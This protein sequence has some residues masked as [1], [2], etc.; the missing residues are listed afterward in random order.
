M[1]RAGL[2]ELDVAP[3][4]V[5]ALADLILDAIDGL[6]LDRLVS[7]DPARS[8]AAAAAFAELLEQVD[9]RES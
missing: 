7:R 8:D 6:L 4:K 5:A 2:T 9:A 1:L 3:P